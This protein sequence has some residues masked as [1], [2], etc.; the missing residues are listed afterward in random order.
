MTWEVVVK[1]E[2]EQG[3]DRVMKVAKNRRTF[4][5]LFKDVKSYKLNFK[6]FTV[7]TLEI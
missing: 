7:R 2:K 4:K 3:K 6:N 5:I 1:M